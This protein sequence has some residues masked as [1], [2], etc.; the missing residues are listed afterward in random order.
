MGVVV[1]LLNVSIAVRYLG[2]EGYGL[3]TV[4]ISVVGWIQ[5]S[6]LGLGLG[7][8]NTLTEQTALGNKETQRELIS[9][10]FF[11]LL[12][13]GVFLVL[14]TILVFPH[15]RWLAL[16]PPSSSRFA[17]EVPRTVALALGCFILALTWGF[18]QPI[19]AARQEL[20]LY[21][22]QGL[23]AN[24]V[25]VVALFAAVK[26]GAGL[27]GV[28]VANIG[29]AAAFSAGFAVWTVFGRG[30]PELRPSPSLMSVSAFRM[31][32]GT[33]IGFLAL[34]L[35]SVVIFQ[36][37]AFLIAQFLSSEQ[38]TPYAVGQRLFAQLLGL[39]GLVTVSLWPAFGHAKALGEVQ[40]MR[41]IYRQVTLFA[42][43]TFALVFLF[44]AFFGHF[45]LSLWVGEVSA[46]ATLLICAIGVHYFLNLWSANHAILLNGLGVIRKQ[47][48]GFSFQAVLGLGL[49]VWLIRK[50]GVI[51][52]PIGGSIAYLSVT[53]WYLPWLFR[54]AL[55][56]IQT[57]A[58]RAEAE[59]SLAVT[60]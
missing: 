32:F 60:S 8:Q 5:F 36:T 12:S 21:Y 53:A 19:Y 47:V 42:M 51:G 3:L 35:C 50:L 38:I 16:F 43:G 31:V 6:N 26:L 40:W 34:Q 58:D 55:S 23:L 44:V 49:S 20:H 56:T 1:G 13:I 17:V 39:M 7:L 28:A 22:L 10:T 37:D 41:R 48:L 27:L 29:V 52:L 46:P 45:L 2:N 11:T 57:G 25:S 15:V 33:G 4:I 18:I 14:L 59:R 54:S 9:T 24:V 30:I